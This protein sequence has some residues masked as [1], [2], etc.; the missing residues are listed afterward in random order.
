M[1]ELF[2]YIITKATEIFNLAAKKH[3]LKEAKTSHVNQVFGARI[4]KDGKEAAIDAISTGESILIHLSSGAVA[5]KE[6]YVTEP[7]TIQEFD[8]EIPKIE[9]Y[10]TDCFSL[11][12]VKRN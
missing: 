9:A 2:D 10:I 1:D 12:V 6:D 5:F 3:G 7:K 8:Q 11:K 4:R